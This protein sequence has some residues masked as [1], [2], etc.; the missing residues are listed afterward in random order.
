MDD[1]V[2]EMIETLQLT[3]LDRIADRHHRHLEPRWPDRPGVWR[4]LLWAASTPHSV[5]IRRVD[6]YGLQLL[7]A[8]L[9]PDSKPVR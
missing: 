3:E 6:A 9:V 2:A 5:A 7:T 4:A 8:D 1:R